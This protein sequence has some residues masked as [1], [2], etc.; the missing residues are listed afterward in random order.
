MTD[1][2]IRLSWIIFDDIPK[3][4]VAFNGDPKG[5]TLYVAQRKEIAD[6]LALK[7]YVKQNMARW[8]GAGSG[9]Y[10]C[11]LCQEEI[12][13]QRKFCPNCGAKMVGELL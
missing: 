11:S 6:A 13:G 4:I 10:Y 12:F 5:L 8:K 2:Q 3:N 1:E 9:Y 7:G